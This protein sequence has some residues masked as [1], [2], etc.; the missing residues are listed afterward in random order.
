[1][2]E[3]R[4]KDG[5]V[6]KNIPDDVSDD[7]IKDRIKNIRAETID[8]TKGMTEF[9]ERAYQIDR[10]GITFAE[11]ALQS[12]ALGLEYIYNMAGEKLS[13]AI[14]DKV[15]NYSINVMRSLGNA[16]RP[17]LE[18]PT[19][20]LG[21]YAMNK[22][23]EA[24]DDFE[25]AYPR[26]AADM[27]AAGTVG[28]TVLAGARPAAKLG[29]KYFGWDYLDDVVRPIK[30]KDMDKAVMRT[31]GLKGK[32]IYPLNIDQKRIKDVLKTV[33]GLKRGFT[34]ARHYEIIR[35]HNMLSAEALK[36]R[37]I[38]SKKFV[39]DREVRRTLERA[40]DNF[41]KQYDL[42][43]RLT[44]EERFMFIDDALDR[45]KSPKN[46]AQLLDARKAAD[47]QFRKF[48]NDRRMRGELIPTRDE[49]K[50][51]STRDSLN[52]LL[53]MKE[54]GYKK[55]IT[56]QHL[57]YKAL[58]TLD[59]KVDAQ[60]VEQNKSFIERHLPKVTSVIMPRVTK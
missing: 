33:P 42:S 16:A 14:P 3:I 15:K 47:F 34:H 57:M 49:M 46:T 29:R 36:E 19:G 12:T 50:W 31:E 20:Q 43:K 59:D 55:E 26:M 11:R 23:G 5:I 27:K 25:R 4:T 54:P 2:Q 7:E 56:R 41:N 44:P 51:R 38:K 6:L 60:F 8:P 24:W 22:G 10:S 40:A 37:L 58:D 17:A 45:I 13:E 18:T 30:I 21:L 9:E 53:E 52:A 28:A 48:S 39:N 1:M 35:D 32:I